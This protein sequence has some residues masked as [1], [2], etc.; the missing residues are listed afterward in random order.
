VTLAC[1]VDRRRRHVRAKGL[2]GIDDIEIG[3]VDPVTGRVTL[4]VHFLGAVPREVSTANVRIDG[5]RRVRGI[6]AVVVRVRA[7]AGEDEDECLEVVLDRVGDDCTYTLCLVEPDKHG[8]PGDQRLAGLDVR[9]WC[10]PFTFT[11]HCAADL[12]CATQ[13]PCPPP[14]RS[15]PPLDYLA[16]DY[17]GFRRLALDRL[18]LLLPEWRE[19]HVPDVGITLVELLASVGDQLSYYQDAVA[20]EAYLDTARQRIS[21]RRHGRLVDYRLH[22][23]TNARA[24]VVFEVQGTL[25]VRPSDL[26]FVTGYAGAPPPGGP[27]LHVEDLPEQAVAGYRWFEPLVDDP[28]APLVFRPSHNALTLYDWGDRECCLPQGATA[29]WVVEPPEGL[30]LVAGDL[31]ALEEVKGAR[32]GAPGDA[33]PDRR[34][35]VRLVEVGDPVRDEVAD[36]DVRE[37]RWAPEDG[38]PFSLCLSAVG[39]A[40]DCE[41]VVGVSVA[42]GNVVLVDEG[43]T[44]EEQLP[45][46]EGPPPVVAC[47]GE[48]MPAERPSAPRSTRQR[49]ARPGLTF[50]EPLPA[51]APTAALH[52]RD[53]AAAVPAVRLHGVGMAE[54]EP[55]EWE[56]RPDLLA[57]GP[58]DRHVAV[59]V[60]DDGTPWLRFGDDRSG[61]APVP[62]TELTARYRVGTGPGGNVGVE[63]IVHPVLVGKADDVAVRVRNPLPAWG[64]RGPEPLGE[65]RMRIPVSFRAVRER[66]VTGDDYAELAQRAA[67]AHVQRSAAAL[68]WTGSWYEAEVTLDARVGSHAACGCAGCA[69]DGGD[70]P[71]E[72]VAVALE[73]VR[74][75]GHDV[76]V[77]VARTVPVDLRLSVC[78]LPGH[79]RAHVKAA[80]LDVLS[81]R[82]LPDGALGWFHPDRWTFGD[83][84]HTGPLLAVAQGVPG[85]ES[86]DVVH[87]SVHGEGERGERAG[88]VLSVGPRSVVALG[89]LAV[90]AR[91]GR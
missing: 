67:G 7:G 42:R 28:A 51:S 8:R 46:V 47:E 83:S 21:V 66:A 91:G 73:R 23:G 40:P 57:S 3:A 44:V 78:V 48:C 38:L 52:E 5:G 70:G 55:E 12:D 35:V 81:D 27:P 86:V 41:S 72:A 50:A 87:L 82:V 20:T 75:M 61:Q 74:R 29:A 79:L 37:L 18:A 89:H 80:L 36:L 2:N 88:G 65:A 56:P 59:E 32:T 14:A 15:E 54:G 22:E 77:E 71:A 31:L 33:D 53:P 9:Y 76:R 43:R 26:A 11:G 64:G 4:C 63:T 13:P 49:L 60:D 58:D 24:F 85:V 34:H 6:R 39:V 30:H 16:K 69:E 17:A 62:G 68:V 84:L 25:E 1:K 19:R 90:E 10:S 45:A